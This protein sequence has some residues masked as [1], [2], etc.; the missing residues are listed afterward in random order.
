MFGMNNEILEYSNFFSS[1]KNINKLKRFE[2]AFN[3]WKILYEK[4]DNGTL[5]KSDCWLLVPEVL[6]NTD[7]TLFDKRQHKIRK[8]IKKYAINKIDYI[9]GKAR[10]IINGKSYK[11]IK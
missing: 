3:Y 5:K 9:G 10:E 11:Y 8:N 7:L 2:N 4:C 1:F 6:S